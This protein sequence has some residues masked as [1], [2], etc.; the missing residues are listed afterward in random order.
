MFTEKRDRWDVLVGVIAAAILV[1]GIYIL[2]R[3]N[4]DEA[5][6]QPAALVSTPGKSPITDVGS[7]LAPARAAPDAPIASVYECWRDEHRILSDQPCGPDA[8]VRQV[9]EPNRMDAQDT[10]SL[11][12]PVY[13]SSRR[14][15]G[16]WSAGQ[17]ANTSNRCSS[18]QEQ[19][20]GINAR[21]RQAY[22]SQEGERF[23]ERLRALTLQRYDAKCIR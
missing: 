9:T 21:M 5:H 23:R 11:Y 17:G 8:S 4:E 13:V 1:S 15:G 20:D 18:I 10:R 19:I 3:G 22:T 12:S 16:T 14:S 6:A 7:S 2:N